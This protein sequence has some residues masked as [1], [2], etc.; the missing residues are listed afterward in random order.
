[1]LQPSK[2]GALLAAAP[3]PP[4]ASQAAISCPGEQQE[5]GQELEKLVGWGVSECSECSSQSRQLVKEEHGAC[6]FPPPWLQMHLA[7][8]AWGLW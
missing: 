2:Q 3:R 5:T 6:C 7:L 1:M 8:P 4:S